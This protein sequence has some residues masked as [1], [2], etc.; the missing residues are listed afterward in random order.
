MARRPGRATLGASAA[1]ATRADPK[2]PS[3]LRRE[4]RSLAASV[5]V[6]GAWV[7]QSRELS[8]LRESPMI[9]RRSCASWECVSRPST[10]NAPI[11]V[12][13]DRSPSATPASRKPSPII[14]PTSAC[15]TG[16]GGVDL[17]Q[18][19][20]LAEGQWKRLK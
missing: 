17:D 2:W 9:A 1:A 19:F 3:P 18:R 4:R 14:V 7:G 11:F 12:I 16:T 5:S 15:I 20:T 6:P 10:T 8:G 13:E